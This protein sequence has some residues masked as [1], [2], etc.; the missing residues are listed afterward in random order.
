[1]KTLTRI[2]IIVVLI[3]GLQ[4]LSSCS[5]LFVANPGI[6]P[7]VF[8]KPIYNDS[9]TISNF[10][11]GK[12]NRSTYLN[13]YDFLTDNY[14]G[15]AYLFQTVTDKYLNSSYGA[16]CYLGKVGVD[17]NLV[18]NYRSYY[19]GGVSADVQFNIPIMSLNLKPLGLKGT[20]LYEDG[21]YSRWRFNQMGL[22][23]LFADKFMCNLSQTAGM[24]YVFRNKNSLGL[25]ISAGYSFMIPHMYMDMTFSVI[26]N[27][28][29][30]RYMIY[31]QK[32]AAIIMSNDDFVIGFNFKL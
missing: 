5:S 2:S 18:T 25:D 11:G 22:P 10:V 29:T 1:M 3:S 31:L 6:D 24:N 21:E 19:G 14:F 27:Y 20:L 4:L 30:P 26:L 16:F 32:S 15:Q 28:T 8:T 7:I 23:G 13:T 9:T 17:E 12:L